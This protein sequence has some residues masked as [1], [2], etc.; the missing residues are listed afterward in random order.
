MKTKTIYY[1]ISNIDTSATSI[2]ASDLIL[3]GYTSVD[4]MFVDVLEDVYDALFLTIDYGDNSPLVL[5]TK[6][7][8]YDYK[9]SSIL[10]EVLYGK[11][12]GSILTKHT[13]EYVN[14]S[15]YDGL[16]F[17]ANF[18]MYFSSGKNIEIV[19]PIF[20]YGGSFYD[21]LKNVSGINS[22]IL[23]VSANTT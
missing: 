16:K 20:L 2:T 10:N 4:F 11:F 22:Q 12:G 8:V 1:N 13:H 17:K 5:L 6:P 14:T 19:Q 3:K 9:T 18:K 15:N 23:P 7:A 21:D